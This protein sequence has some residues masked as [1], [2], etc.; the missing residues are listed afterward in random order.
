MTK[1]E[2]EQAVGAGTTEE[3]K[4][5][6]LYV[7]DNFALVKWP[8]GSYWSGMCGTSY[9][10]PRVTRHDMHERLQ[11]GD[12]KEVWNCSHGADGRLTPRRLEALIAREKA[13]LD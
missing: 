2:V 10:S 5:K 7:D 13:A 3:G 1:E 8:G 11:Y 12:R 6:C 4:V 9:C